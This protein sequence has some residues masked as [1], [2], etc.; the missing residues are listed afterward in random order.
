MQQGACNGK[1]AALKHAATETSG[2]SMQS[3]KLTKSQ[4]ERI[5]AQK[6]AA[7]Q[8]RQKKQEDANAR[9]AEVDDVALK[10]WLKNHAPPPR[11]EDAGLILECI[12]NATSE[13]FRIAAPSDGSI[14][15]RRL[16]LEKYLDNDPWLLAPLSSRSGHMPQVPQHEKKQAG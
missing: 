2:A 11:V 4:H 3:S 14:Q 10:Q 8:K 15:E 7:M 5:Q 9:A 1:Q 16:A 6:A 13:L 12:P